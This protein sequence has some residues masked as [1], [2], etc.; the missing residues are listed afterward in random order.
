M[1]TLAA[2]LLAIL[3]ACLVIH[4]DRKSKQEIARA[5]QERIKELDRLLEYDE[6][7]YV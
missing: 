2:I 4:W 1:T 3:V 5:K 6:N 7:S